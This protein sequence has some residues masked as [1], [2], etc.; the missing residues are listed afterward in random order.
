MRTNQKIAAWI[1]ILSAF[2]IQIPYTYL[3]VKFNYPQ[4]LR[5][6]PET[7]L[8]TFKMGGSTLVMAWWFFGFCG[9][10]LLFSYLVLYE[11]VKSKNEVVAKLALLFGILALVFQ[12]IGLLRWVFVVPILANMLSNSN[13][14][15]SLKDAVIVSFISIHHLFGVLIGEHLGQLF[16]IIWMF[17]NSSI[18]KAHE[19]FGKKLAYFGYIASFLYLLA[20]AELFSLVIPEFRKIPLAG[21]VGSLAWLFWMVF[22]GISMLRKNSFSK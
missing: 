9:L 11:I 21:L 1:F 22:I 19:I 13:I 12:L 15:P 3:I 16:T 5:Q 14:N 6:S 18:M 2:A 8:T 20:Q 4:I 7:I 17:L 10:P